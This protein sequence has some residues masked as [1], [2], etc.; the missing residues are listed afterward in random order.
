MTTRDEVVTTR[1]EAVTTGAARLATTDLGE[2]MA[3]ASK[4]RALR[5]TFGAGAALL[6]ALLACGDDA[7][8]AATAPA[9]TAAGRAAA[10][11][12][13]G[14]TTVLDGA[15]AAFGDAVL[16]ELTGD[17]AQARAQF[18]HVLG[19]S[20]VPPQLTARAALHLAQIEL[21][22]GQSRRALDLAARARAVAPGDKVIEEGVGTIQAEFV[23]SAGS[24]DIR[25]PAIGT[26]LQ[27]VAPDVAEAFAKAEAGLA[28][29]HRRRLQLLFGETQRSIDIRIN[30]T[31]SVV[32]QYR[33]VAASG[34]VALVA[35]TYRIGT[36]YHDLALDLSVAEPPAEL[37]RDPARGL[38]VMLSNLAFT[39]LRKAEAEYRACMD[40]P[41]SPESELWR[42]A[43]QT[44]R[45]SVV[46]VL[47]ARGVRITDR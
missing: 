42:L 12:A 1:R 40:A 16:A 9:A 5:V 38:R 37:M 33:A 43:A 25:G 4:Q 32:A 2:A 46:D 31:A 28:Q 11:P 18:E 39:Y 29:V 36:L 3:P 8:P 19:G 7:A 21:R 24:G 45:R 10:D 14:A 26:P 34:G 44:Y 20:D 15:G 35:A 30:A 6:C 47:V 13:L 23:D 41:Q 22:A 27:G 17:E